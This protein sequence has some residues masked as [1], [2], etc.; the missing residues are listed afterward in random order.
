MRRM[1]I[2]PVFSVAMKSRTFCPFSPTELKSR[3]AGGGSEHSQTDSQLADGNI[4]CHSCHAQFLNGGWV[5]W[6]GSALLVSVSLNSL[7][8]RSPR[9]SKS[10][11]FFRSFEKFSKFVSL[12]L[13]DRCLGTDCESVIGGEKNVCSLFPYS[14][15]SL[16]LVIVLLVLVFPLM[17]Y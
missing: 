11:V 14:L 1:L 10:S 6:Q 5:G 17:S 13:C 15:L 12:A 8:A 4:P 3:C 16:L 7:L 2:T 9:F